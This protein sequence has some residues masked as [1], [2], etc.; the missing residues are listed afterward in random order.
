M[1]G[2]ARLLGAQT[3]HELAKLLTLRGTWWSGGLA[4]ALAAPLCWLTAH[5]MSGEPGA[6]VDSV[7][8]LALRTSIPALVCVMVLAV[9]SVRA[10]VDSGVWRL[11]TL[12]VR[13]RSGAW[14]AK[15]VAVT[16]VAAGLGIVIAMVELLVVAIVLG[17]GDGI[18]S[19]LWSGLAIGG[20]FALVMAGWAALG[21]AAGALLPTTGAALAVALGLPLV[22]EPALAAGG[23]RWADLLPF[24]SGFATLGGGSSLFDDPWIGV[25]GSAVLFVSAAVAAVVAGGWRAR[26]ADL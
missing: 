17:G 26:T 7:T 25:G 2:G 11:S 24:A 18:E 4:V 8:R 5:A 6:S 23:G 1:R 14:T 19:L 12:R 13:G 22:I 3:R 16:S 21:M 10:D 15:S 9:G 20:T